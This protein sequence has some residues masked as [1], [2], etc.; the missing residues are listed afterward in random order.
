MA[1]PGLIPAPR[2]SPQATCS[3]HLSK[4]M[5]PRRVPRPG[6]VRAPLLRRRRPYDAAAAQP[7]IRPARR[8]PGE[9]GSLEQEPAAFACLGADG[10][11]RA[12]GRD[13]GV[14]ARS[15]GDCA[16]NAAAA[17]LMT[18]AAAAR[19]LSGGDSGTTGVPSLVTYALKHGSCRAPI[20]TQGWKQRA[21]PT[22]SMQAI[23]ELPC[24]DALQPRTR[25]PPEWASAVP[26]VP[27]KCSSIKHWKIRLETWRLA[28]KRCLIRAQPR[29]VSSRNW[30]SFM[31]LTKLTA[32][33][34]SAL[35]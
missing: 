34:G 9:D 29:R 35:A 5:P 25:V 12:L 11:A 8:T 26:R 7:L 3:I 4:S 21:H 24:R 17:D 30:E 14:E 23:P 18:A 27:E 19:P 2:P 10:P 22:T 15:G 16:R 28:M 13:R 32:Q 1:G 20:E 33:N 31:R 6:E